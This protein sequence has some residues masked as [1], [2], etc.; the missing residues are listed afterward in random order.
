MN[1]AKIAACSAAFG[2]GL[3]LDIVLPGS[4]IPF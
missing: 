2:E 4:L 3:R 1:K